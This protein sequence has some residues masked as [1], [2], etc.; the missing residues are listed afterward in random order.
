M[1]SRKFLSSLQALHNAYTVIEKENIDLKNPQ[2]SNDLSYSAQKISSVVRQIDP[3]IKLLRKHFSEVEERHNSPENEE[4][5]L[6]IRTL[7]SKLEREKTNPS[8]CKKIIDAIAEHTSELKTSQTTTTINAPLNN[9]PLEIRS[10]ISADI[11]E[12]QRTFNAKC[13]RSCVILCGRILEVALHRKYYEET[14]HDILEKSPGIG[15]GTLLAKMREKEIFFDPGLMNQIHLINM[16]RIFCVHKKQEAFSPSKAQA[17][18]I[19]IYTM[20]VLRRLFE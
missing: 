20:D 11:E 12:L 14:N 2:L 16:T 1:L 10:E 6:Q 3:R 17:Q 5:L 18:A 13:Y 8:E 4:S 19:I 7:L 9:I 15:L